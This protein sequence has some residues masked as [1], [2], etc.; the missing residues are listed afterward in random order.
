M[1][2]LMQL[3]LTVYSAKFSSCK[4]TLLAVLL[5]QLDGSEASTITI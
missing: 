1:K 3:P 4:G 5:V 2:K